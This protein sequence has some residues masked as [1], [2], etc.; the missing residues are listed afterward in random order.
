[1]GELASIFQQQGRLERAEE[2][3]TIVLEKRRKNFGDDHPHTRWTMQGLAN[4]Y[5][6][7][8][9]LQAAQELERLIGGQPV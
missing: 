4:L 7:I 8:G 6:R 5:R 9:E 2:L 3:L 1:M